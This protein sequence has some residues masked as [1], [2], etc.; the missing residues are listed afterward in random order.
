MF[1]RAPERMSLARG[2]FLKSKLLA[3]KARVLED[4][5]SS[6]CWIINKM[7]TYFYY[8]NSDLKLRI[9]FNHVGSCKSNRSYPACCSSDWFTWLTTKD[10]ASNAKHTGRSKM[11]STSPWPMVENGSAAHVHSQDAQEKSR[12]SLDDSTPAERIIQIQNCA[13]ECIGPVV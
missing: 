5:E 1:V 11:C 4:C 8:I 9:W 2:W 6:T 3:S 7:L 10:S 13:R 12:K